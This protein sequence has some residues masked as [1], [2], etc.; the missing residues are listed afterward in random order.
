MLLSCVCGFVIALASAAS[1]AAALPHPHGPDGAATVIVTAHPLTPT[2]APADEYFGRFKLSNLGVRNIIHA[3]FVEGD[4]PLALPLERARMG[5][6]DSALNEWS[7]KYPRDPWLQREVFS[8]ATVLAGKGDPQ[9]SMRALDLL[10]Q[11]ERRYPNTRASKRALSMIRTLTCP[12]TVD[13]TVDQFVPPGFDQLIYPAF[14]KDEK[15]GA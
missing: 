4:S 13:L 15:T 3:F 12:T 10:M 9:T 14:E 2:D 6:V 11:A 1:T 7:D 5:E 8:Y